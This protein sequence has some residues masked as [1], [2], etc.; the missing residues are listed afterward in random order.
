MSSN[1]SKNFKNF[2]DLKTFLRDEFD[3]AK[4]FVGLTDGEK[5]DREHHQGDGQVTDVFDQ[6]HAC[7]GGD[8]CIVVQEQVACGIIFQVAQTTLTSET[9]FW[10]Q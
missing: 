7:P 4:K 10:S 2:N 1:Y 8:S 3:L 6:Q 5:G 9:I